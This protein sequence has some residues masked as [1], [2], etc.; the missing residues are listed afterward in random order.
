MQDN[1]N[2]D[3]ENKGWAQMSALLDKERPVAIPFWKRAWRKLALGLILFL[4]S[5]SLGVYLYN[6]TTN[7]TNKTAII[8]TVENSVNQQVTS[9]NSTNAPSITEATLPSNTTIQNSSQLVNSKANT[10]STNRAT[11]VTS[12]NNQVANLPLKSS[13]TA[14]ESGGKATQEAIFL[15]KGMKKILE[16]LILFGC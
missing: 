9:V 7:F 16:E 15:K 5:F 1:Y 2:K 12:N 4:A 13:V 3:L 6:T 11:N 14:R 8:Q 10:L